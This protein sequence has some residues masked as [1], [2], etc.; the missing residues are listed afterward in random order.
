[1]TN[2]IFNHYKNYIINNSKELNYIRFC[3]IE[4]I[5]SFPRIDP[6]QMAASII[7]NGYKVIFDD[8]TI[9]KECNKR[10]ERKVKNLMK[11]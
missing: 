2:N 7:N 1:M 8:S 4:Y 6:Y 3:V 11:G 5:C 10:K 9:S